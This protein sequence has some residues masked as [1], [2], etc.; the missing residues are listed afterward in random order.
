M[1]P[2][3]LP[4]LL[5]TQ[6]VTAEQLITQALLVSHSRSAVLRPFVAVASPPLKCAVTGPALPPPESLSAN[7]LQPEPPLSQRVANVSEMSQS[8]AGAACSPHRLGG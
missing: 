8:V 1:K 5:T 4:S 6:Q 3:G 2:P 7:D